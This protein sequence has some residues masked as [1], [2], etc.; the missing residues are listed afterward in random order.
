MTANKRPAKFLWKTS[1]TVVHTVNNIMGLRVFVFS[2][3]PET[4]YI[5]RG[6]AEYS[7]LIKSCF[8]LF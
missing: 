6:R 5:G 2:H 1:K 4:I 3:T 8:H 7:N